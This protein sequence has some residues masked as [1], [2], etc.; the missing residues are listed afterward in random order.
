MNRG[1]LPFHPLSWNSPSFEAAVVSTAKVFQL[2]STDRVWQ[3]PSNRTVRLSA[4]SSVDYWIAFGASTLEITSTSGLRV[5][6]DTVEAFHVPA[7]VEYLSVVSSTNVTV[8]VTPG[9][10]Y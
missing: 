7:G 9:Y 6:G 2:D 5:L 8:N 3:G 10:G 4:A 1:S